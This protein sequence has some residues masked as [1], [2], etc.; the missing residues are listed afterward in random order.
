MKNEL[1]L[2]NTAVSLI[3]LNTFDRL[4]GRSIF[5]LL[6]FL[7][8]SSCFCR[9]VAHQCSPFYIHHLVRWA[10]LLLADRDSSRFPLGFLRV[11]WRSKTYYYALFVKWNNINITFFE[12]LI[13]SVTKLQERKR[14]LWSKVP[15]N[16]SL[17]SVFSVPFRPLHRKWFQSGN[18]WR[19]SNRCVIL[20]NVAILAVDATKS[21]QKKYEW[22]QVLQSSQRPNSCPLK[23]PWNC[24]VKSYLRQS[25][26]L[27]HTPPGS[28]LV[29]ACHFCD[30]ISRKSRDA[31][32]TSRSRVSSTIVE[33]TT[34]DTC[35]L[36]CS[37][38]PS[39]VFTYND[40]AMR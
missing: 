27:P 20:S 38:C 32:I 9:H 6:R 4:P 29:T 10:S 19:Q 21:R 15:W 35:R 12:R 11:M 37:P 30:A 5:L 23:L 14:D 34:K 28:R 31:V 7:R 25:R 8:R 36:Y 3:L 39:R 26:R 18:K 13:L 17:T 1:P 33:C 22:A 16:A 40:T 2:Y 24:Q